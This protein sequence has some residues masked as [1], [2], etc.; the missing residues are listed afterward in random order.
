VQPG[1][2]YRELQG[3]LHSHK[4]FLPPYPASIDFATI[5]G[6]VA[7]N[8]AGEKTI[9]YGSTRDYVQSLRVV[10][11][12]GE[13]IETRRLSPKELRAKQMQSNFEGHLYRNVDY[14]IE[15]NWDTILEAFPRVSKN[16]AGYNLWHV[17]GR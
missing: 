11:A 16:S 1:M 6:A 13:V 9:K 5:G 8:S 12:N 15:E 7:N 4:R 14:L 17:K 10:L 3:V 2:I